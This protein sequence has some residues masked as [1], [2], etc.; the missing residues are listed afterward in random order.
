MKRKIARRLFSGV[1]SCSN[2]RSKILRTRKEGMSSLGLRRRC[3]TISMAIISMVIRMRL[4][5]NI[6]T[7]LPMQP[8]YKKGDKRIKCA[9]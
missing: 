1:L 4:G 6:S 9:R 3:S 7:G 8:S 2:V 5:S